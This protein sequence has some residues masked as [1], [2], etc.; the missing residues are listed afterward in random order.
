MNVY[1][2]DTQDP[3]GNL[4]GIYGDVF[5]KNALTVFSYSYN[6]SPAVG[7]QQLKANSGSTGD[8]TGVSVVTQ[9]YNPGVV[10][11]G[12]LQRTGTRSGVSFTSSAAATATS[13]RSS[14]GRLEI[15]GLAAV[16]IASFGV[17]FGMAY[18]L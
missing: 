7:F 16:M 11:S 2:S 1:A 12:T 9:T 15:R 4:I 14:A 6:G 13:A 8:A 17:L 18:I 3:N 5:I 10:T